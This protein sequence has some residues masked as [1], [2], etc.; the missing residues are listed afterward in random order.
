MSNRSVVGLNEILQLF[1][2]ELSVAD[3]NASKYLG[4]IS[5]AIVKKRIELNMTQKEFASHMSVSQGM[6]S[7]WE[8]GDCNFTVK[9]LAEIAEKLDLS[10]YIGLKEYKANNK[11]T[12]IRSCQ[13]ATLYTA[14]E[15]TKYVRDEVKTCKV[16]PMTPKIYKK[17]S[18]QSVIMFNKERIQM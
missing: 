9:T 5:A 15:E 16:I 17:S 8:S 10:L 3:I 6:V 7:K 2:S 4:K 12:T 18:A 13:S 14:S 11:N 1:E